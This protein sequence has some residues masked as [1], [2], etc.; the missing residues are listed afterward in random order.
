MYKKNITIVNIFS[1]YKKNLTSVMSVSYYRKKT[2]F[3]NTCV[4][5]TSP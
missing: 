1:S 2:N 3:G 5:E 4:P